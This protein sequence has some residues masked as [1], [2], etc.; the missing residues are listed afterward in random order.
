MVFKKNNKRNNINIQN[1]FDE[2]HNANKLALSVPI[3]IYFK[4]K[5]YYKMQ[6]C[7][8]TKCIDVILFCN[9]TQYEL[10]VSVN[11]KSFYWDLLAV[12]EAMPI[13]IKNNYICQ[14]CIENKRQS[15]GSLNELLQDH[16]FTPFLNWVNNELATSKWLILEDLSSCTSAYIST[17]RPREKNCQTIINIKI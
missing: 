6:F 10:C 2:W 4:D 16:L 13:K 17:H 5:Q 12:F 7:G 14:L 11:Y 3:F 15:F 1:A 9:N 8:I